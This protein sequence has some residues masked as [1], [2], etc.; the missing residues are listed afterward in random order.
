MQQR[1]IVLF[2]GYCNLCSW[3]VH[4]ILKHDKQKRFRFCAL[5][6]TAAEKLFSRFNYS[7][8]N[9]S[10]VLLVDNK[11]FLKST[12]VLTICKQLKGFW[13]LIYVFIIVPSFIRDGVYDFIAKHRYKWYG[14]QSNCYI[15]SIEERERF[16]S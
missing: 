14:K 6:S 13:P 10:V 9:K 11:I 1:P 16:I 3:W 5:Q 8:K 2:D 4:F 15:P 12:A 7:E